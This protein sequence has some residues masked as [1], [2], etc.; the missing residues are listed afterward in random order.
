MTPWRSRPYLDLSY[1][2]GK[3]CVRC[4]KLG[5]EPCHYSGQYSDRLGKGGAQKSFDAAVA[6]LCRECHVYFDL[7]HAGNDDVRAAEFLMLVLLTLHRNLQA[8]HIEIVVHTF[9]EG[10]DPYASKCHDTAREAFKRDPRNRKKG[11]KR[12]THTKTP[13]KCRIGWTKGESA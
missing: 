5:C 9:L 6:D 10:R 13:D 11:S 2:E 8:G 4:G 3:T 1:V 7:Y 12:G